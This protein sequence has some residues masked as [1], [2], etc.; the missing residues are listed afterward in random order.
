MIDIVN[1]IAL[2]LGYSV[3]C[4]GGIFVV[5]LIYWMVLEF[6]WRRMKVTPEFWKILNAWMKE[7]RNNES[8]N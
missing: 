2:I 4:I 6:T 1:M 8:P 5:A 3:M 7:R